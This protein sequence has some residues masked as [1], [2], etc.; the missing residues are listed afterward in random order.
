MKHILN[1]FVSIQE[2]LIFSVTFGYGPKGCG[3]DLCR[4]RQM[5]S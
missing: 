4:A 5:Y 2:L 3:F 1:Y